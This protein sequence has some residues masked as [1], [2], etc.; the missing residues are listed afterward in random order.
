MRGDPKTTRDARGAQ[1]AAANFG[2]QRRDLE[3]A[4]G[5]EQRNGFFESEGL[6]FR[7][8]V[9]VRPILH[10]RRQGGAMML[11]PIAHRLPCP[12]GASRPDPVGGL[13]HPMRSS[14][15]VISGG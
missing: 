10:A 9:R 8:V 5:K 13:S 2:A 7:P 3:R 1:V 6:F 12:S 14:I 15:G 11:R 4:L